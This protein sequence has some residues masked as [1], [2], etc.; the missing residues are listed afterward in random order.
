MA[1]LSVA[2]LSLSSFIPVLTYASP[3][4]AGLFL[5]PVIEEL[6]LKWGWMVW[7][8]VSVLSAILL[9]DKEAA[10]FYI[11]TGYYPMIKPMLEKIRP[12][13]LK[14]AA[15]LAVFSVTIGI[16]YLIL[17]YVLKLDAVINEFTTV[18]RAV[19]IT[20]YILIVL[21]MLIYDL[22]VAKVTL[23]YKKRI[24]P[25]MKINLKMIAFFLLAGLMMFS[26]PEKA[27]A[28]TKAVTYFGNEWPVNFLNSEHCQAE[29]DF[30]QIK[31]DG[32]N[33]VIYCVPWREIQP[34]SRDG[35]DEASVNKLD[36]MI[37]RAEASGLKVMLR[38]GYTWDF[39]DQFS[40]INRFNNLFRNSGEMNA[41]LRYAQKVYEVSSAHSNFAGAF[42]TWEDFWPSLAQNCSGYTD[43]DRKL[44]ELLTQ[45]QDVFP[46]LSMECRLHNDMSGGKVYS[47]EN[48]FGCG[49]AP[50]S[51]AML[52]VSM[53]F[54]DGTV[55][56]PAS[57]AN[58]SSQMISRVQAAGKPVFIDQF[59]YMEST[60]GY[61]KLAN[62][63]DVNA[64]L[65]AM[66]DVFNRQT[67]GYG[68]WA[69]R[70]Y[71][72]SIIYNP[73]FG[74][75]E[76]GW[77]FYNARVEDVNGNKK[78]YLE[79][80]ASISQSLTGRGFSNS[81]DSK[82]RMT[83]DAAENGKINM[84]VGGESRSVDIVQGSQVVEVDFGKQVKGDIRISASVPVYVDNVKLYSHIT[85]GNIYKLD[86]TPGE[87]LSGIRAMNNK[88]K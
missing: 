65:S 76:K 10:A 68:I 63:S 37:G 43:M 44:M 3:L 87:Y 52:A 81:Y 64:Y 84:T 30:D 40:S 77:K 34:E 45:T 83:V 1:A 16:M 36:E 74:R 47:H 55:V 29:A 26:R 18:S 58:M 86:G 75:G 19:N 56:D 71:A 59:L 17:C 2:I 25:K 42:I 15:K 35:F 69:Y 20:Y 72:D 70:D 57:A 39:A 7:I 5:I 82:A 53:G 11:F 78:A 54:P 22:L 80:G 49:S 41:W 67:M 13:P 23:L 73:E 79:S 61:E 32:F 8:S 38:L 14:I 60:P 28:G 51:S 24:K 66:A 27:F 50:Y 21:I 88:I 85:E 31:K 46:N 9:A 6:G 62:V 12:K 4:F 33:T 48:T